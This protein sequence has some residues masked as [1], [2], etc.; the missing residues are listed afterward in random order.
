MANPKQLFRGHLVQ[1]HGDTHRRTRQ[2]PLIIQIRSSGRC[3]SQQQRRRAGVGDY[4]H[5]TLWSKVE[6]LTMHQQMNTVNRNASKCLKA[7]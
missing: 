6:T 2:P 1:Q 7:H 4:L 3:A 5:G